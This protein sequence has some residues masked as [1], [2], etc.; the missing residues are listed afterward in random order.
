M[1]QET[2]YQVSLQDSIIAGHLKFFSQNWLVLSSNGRTLG[3]I[4]G[5]KV[6]QSQVPPL[7]LLPPVSVMAP[8]PH[9]ASHGQELTQLLQC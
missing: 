1:T 7:S 3:T 8:V 9:Q 6:P 2:F 4:A 5:Y